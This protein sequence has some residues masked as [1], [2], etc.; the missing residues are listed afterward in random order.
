MMRDHR[1]N[2]HLVSLL[3]SRDAGTFQMP[4]EVIGRAIST[5]SNLSGRLSSFGFS[6]TIAHGHCKSSC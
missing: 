3:A 1:L 6:G 4:R 5:S 2:V